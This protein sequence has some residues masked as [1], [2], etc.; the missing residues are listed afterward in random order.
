MARYRIVERPSF[1]N[2]SEPIFA[3][4]KKEWFWWNHVGVFI[5][6]AEAFKR[7]LELQEADRKGTVKTRVV[8]EFN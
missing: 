1:S 2:P 6:F 7:A 3:V 4:E 5:T 8:E